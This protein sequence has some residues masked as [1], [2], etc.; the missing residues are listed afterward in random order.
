VARI[1]NGDIMAAAI[2]YHLHVVGEATTRRE[3]CR[4]RHLEIG[5]SGSAAARGPTPE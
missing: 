5:W 4:K 1:F 3:A 2:L